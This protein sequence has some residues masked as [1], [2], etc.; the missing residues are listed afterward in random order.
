LHEPQSHLRLPSV[1]YDLHV[2]RTANKHHVEGVVVGA[3]A[4]TDARHDDVVILIGRGDARRKHNLDARHQRI[5]VVKARTIIE[6]EALSIGLDHLAPRPD[7]KSDVVGAGNVHQDVDPGFALFLQPSPCPQTVLPRTSDVI[8]E[9]TSSPDRSTAHRHRR[10]ESDAAGKHVG[11]VDASFEVIGCV[12][13]P[14]DL[15]RDQAL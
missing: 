9:E 10:H 8:V 12:E 5:T 4:R 1:L 13:N 14:L 11:G 15:L 2:A 7:E 3:V 6:V